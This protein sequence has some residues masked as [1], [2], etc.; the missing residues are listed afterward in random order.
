M[1]ASGDLGCLYSS[2]MDGTTL[3][4]VV[5]TIGVGLV[6]IA[7]CSYLFRRKGDRNASTPK[8]LTKSL[9]PDDAAERKSRITGNAV[10][11]VWEERRQRGIQ[12]A[13]LHTKKDV[14]GKNEKPF[15]SSYYYAHNS[16]KTTGG[17]KD[18]LTMEDFTMNGPRLLSR[19]GTPVLNDDPSIDLQQSNPDA[20]KSVKGD[21]C[22]HM[23]TVT[24]EHPRR[25]VI[26]VSKYLWDDP[27]NKDG[28]ATIRVDTL[29]A[30][31]NS[32][33]EMLDWKII[34]PF[35]TNIESSVTEN[36]NG[37]DG[38]H[39]KIQA[40]I[41][42]IGSEDNTSLPHIVDSKQAMLVEYILQIPRLYGRVQKVEC[43]S[44][45]K[46]LLIRL[47][48]QSTILDKSNLKVWPHPQKKVGRA[49][50]VG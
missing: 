46:R 17:Y 32:A 50:F 3:Q 42:T 48:K 29:A 23:N 34:R 27:G 31:K 8:S 15:G 4:M 18:G 28:I 13:S 47:Y 12:A 41:A 7:S 11:D 33:N 26:Q 44:K 35:I 30:L 16:T 36:A 24:S 1:P 38:L 2:K 43:I 39:V 20:D 22:N 19:N 14:T 10:N 25:R 9:Q 40:T 6:T 37:D 21:A 49:S 5:G 45:E